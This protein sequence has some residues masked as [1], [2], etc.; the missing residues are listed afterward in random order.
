MIY[1]EKMSA[2]HPELEFIAA[3]R[4]ESRDSLRANDLTAFGDSQDRWVR[5]MNPDKEK[6]YFIY[7]GPLRY[8][9]SVD[10]LVGY[11]GLDKINPVHR[12]AEMSLLIAPGKRNMKYGSMA[13]SE[14]LKMAFDDFNLNC[15]F[16]EVVGTTSNWDFWEKQGFKKE[17]MLK[18]RF[19]KQ[20]R[21]YNSTIG[22]ITKEDYYG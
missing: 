21:Y 18:K 2:K 9:N 5:E 20:N 13:V 17:G 15:V 10:S 4:D 1:L 7:N 8:K 22:S 12:T 3:W 11:C 19:F 6:Y 16:V 14:L